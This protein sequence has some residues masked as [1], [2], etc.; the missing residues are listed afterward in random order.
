MD[1]S[2]PR[3]LKRSRL[4]LWCGRLWYTFLRYGTWYFGGLRF[5][6]KA[7][8]PGVPTCIFATARRFCAS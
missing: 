1:Q 6:R 4:R 2:A 5:A 3:P 7:S 8:A